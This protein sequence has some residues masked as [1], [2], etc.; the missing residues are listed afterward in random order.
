MKVRPD[1][2]R[3]RAFWIVDGEGVNGYVDLDDP[4][5]LDLEYTKIIASVLD[6]LD[7][8]NIVHI[9]GGGLMLPRYILSKRPSVLQTV[10]EP[11]MD[12]IEFIGK[13]LKT[14]EGFNVVNTTGEEGMHKLPDNFTDLTIVDGFVN[15][16]VPRELMTEG[17]F[18]D[19]Y[20]T[21]NTVIF[22]T[23][24]T[25]PI[26]VP[27]P[28]YEYGLMMAP[29]GGLTGKELTN[30]MFMWSR[31]PLPIEKIRQNI[32]WKVVEINNYDSRTT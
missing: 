7:F 32:P 8:G 27:V 28:I 11:D 30:I 25:L 24:Q 15:G 23:I 18:Q 5:N 4:E 16:L 20:R 13:T 1:F 17:F 26:E 6:I 19:L 31:D 9:G 3:P 2:F 22:N 10:F 29:E 14:L 21:S 12:M